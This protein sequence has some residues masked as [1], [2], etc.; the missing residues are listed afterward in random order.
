MKRKDLEPRRFPTASFISAIAISLLATVWLGWSGF[1]AYEIAEIS[2]E[3]SASFERIKGE[4]IHLDE[5]LTMSAR[6]AAATG[7]LHWEE[8]YRRFEP[9]LDAAIE[10]ALIIAPGAIS[11][12]TATQDAH[13][14]LLKIE[15]FAFDLVRSGQ[16]AAARA[17]LFSDSYET[18]KSI[19]AQGMAEFIDQVQNNVS[20]VLR[21]E[22]N[23]V[24]WSLSTA[25][26]AIAFSLMVW[27]LVLMRIKE[28][29]R[30]LVSEYEA[31][32]QAEEALRQS[33]EWYALTASGANDGL[34]DW[35]T[36]TNESYFS[37]RWK[38][39]L[40]FEDHELDNVRQTFADSLHPDDRDRVMAAVRAHLDARVPYDIE[41][42]LRHKDGHY[43][44]VR[45]KGQA[46]WDEQGNARRMAGSISDIT[47]RRQ[48][49]ETM[50][51]AKEQAELANSTKSEFLANM[52]HE[53][54]TPLNAILGFSE[55]M[56]NATLGPLGNP[57]YEEYVR[58]IN[59]SGRH[60]LALIQDILDLSKIEA[61]KLTLDEEDIDV[62]MTIRSCMVLVKERARNGGVK[63][64]TDIPDGSPALHV[65]QRKL[66]QIL[67]N[68]LSNA[69][70][71]TPAG[72]EVTLKA[73]SRPDSGYVF[74]VIDTGIGIALADIPTALSHFGQVDS[75]LSRKYTGT[76]L[77]LPLTK[78]LVE[79][80]G[81]SL[82]LQSEVG[83]G[84]TVTVRFPSE[85]IVHLAEAAQT[86][87]PAV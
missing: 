60:L 73:W 33:E 6:M 19:Y 42:Q 51:Q 18:H 69:V 16:R 15:N 5:V 57:K 68:L 55:L 79:M 24:I 72:G 7:D 77:G 58:D 22:R 86:G 56:G 12:V 23:R 62:A 67:V 50:R 1:H 41:F 78:S 53:L 25:G 29:R 11:A 85:R 34:W 36:L 26:F 3:R 39:I 63:L 45:S 17:M 71:F 40:G 44:W 65:D 27:I 30:A 81:G 20:A 43:V 38:Q 75:A 14:K 2:R 4:I 87:S 76:G 48:A 59:D 84:T 37:P 49:A 66:K 32:T 47:L 31:R 54:R 9:Q 64:K 35:N 46:I 21:S 80:H 52:S 28:W 13:Q 8:R 82:D 83:A 61:G 10:R 74:Q 70:K